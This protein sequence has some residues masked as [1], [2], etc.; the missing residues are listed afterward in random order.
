MKTYICFWN[1]STEGQ[2]VQVMATQSYFHRNI[3][4][5]K[6]IC[7]EKDL[8]WD[9]PEQGEKYL[10]SFDIGDHTLLLKEDTEFFMATNSL[11]LSENWWD[12]Q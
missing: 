2:N 4:F 1:T 7:L 3:A 6:Q 11:P 5:S 10:L 12:Q 9:I 8:G